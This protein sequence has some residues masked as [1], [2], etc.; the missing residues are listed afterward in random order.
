MR[1]E[2]MKHRILITLL[3]GF[4]AALSA[5][6]VNADGYQNSPNWQNQQSYPIPQLYPIGQV[7][8]QNYNPAPAAPQQYYYPQQQPLPQPQYQPY[9]PWQQ[10]QPYYYDQGPYYDPYSGQ[11]FYPINNNSNPNQYPAQ[12]Y[13]Y[14]TGQDRGVQ[15]N[16]QW[17]SN[18]SL[19]LNWMIRNVTN[20]NWGKKNIDIKCISGCHLLTNP[21]QTLWDLPYSVQRGDTLSFSV[22][23]WQP[24]YGETMAFSIVAGSK[25]LYTFSVNP[26]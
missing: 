5:A 2:K 9:Q 11:Y 13:Y 18:G 3:L 4:I 14:P 20:E 25:T 12:P 6:S 10:T 24:M 16:K 1:E 8:N 17:N 22:N 19:N 23:I 15:V 7:P 21:N 26:N